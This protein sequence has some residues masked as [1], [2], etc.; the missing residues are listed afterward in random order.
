MKSR[1]WQGSLSKALEHKR[2]LDNAREGGFQRAQK[3]VPVTPGLPFLLWSGRVK[4]S[5]GI[6]PRKSPARLEKL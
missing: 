1:H 4:G 5:K 3:V 2:E 6:G